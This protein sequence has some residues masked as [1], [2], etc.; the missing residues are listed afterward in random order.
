M[1]RAKVEGMGGRGRGEKGWFIAFDSKGE[2][3]LVSSLGEAL[4]GWR[5]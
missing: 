2:K 5:G 3:E 1:K 4:K